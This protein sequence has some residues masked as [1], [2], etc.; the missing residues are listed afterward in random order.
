MCANLSL[1]NILQVCYMFL[2]VIFVE[3]RNIK[4]GQ[5]G[6]AYFCRRFKLHPHPP[7]IER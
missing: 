4:V 3:T 6:Y 7:F 5:R 2:N 1:Q